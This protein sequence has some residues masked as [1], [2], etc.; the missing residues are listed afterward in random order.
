MPVVKSPPSERLLADHALACDVVRDA[1]RL[2]LEYFGGEY[3]K[4]HKGDDTPVSEAD[5]AVNDLLQKSLHEA[6]PHYGWLSEETEDDQSRL[7]KERVWVVDPIDGTRAFIRGKPHFTICVALVTEGQVESGVVYNPALDE[8]YE[9]VLGG[10]ARLNGDAIKP[11]KTKE[12]EGCKMAAFGPLFQHPAWPTPWPEMKIVD[13]NSVAYRLALVASGAVDAAIALNT[14]NDWD[15]AAADII[16]H[17]AG[18]KL[19]THD[20]R[21]LI[22]NKTHTGHKSFLSSGPTLYQVLSER[23]APVP[24]P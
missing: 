5:L 6:R 4:W 19:T 16:V 15:L 2:S 18:G 10:G 12:I 3:E 24:L 21:R 1:G 7:G 8:F 9:A 14:K 23:V 11:S 17:E 13:R 22:Y 20:G